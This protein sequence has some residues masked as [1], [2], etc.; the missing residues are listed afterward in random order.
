MN[1]D[2][3]RHAEKIATYAAAVDRAGFAKVER[4]IGSFAAGKLELAQDAHRRQQPEIVVADF[5]A[6]A[7]STVFDDYDIYDVLRAA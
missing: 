4:M 7:Q 3:A 6:D 2:R 5:L 1:V